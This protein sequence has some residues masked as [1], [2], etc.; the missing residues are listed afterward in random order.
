MRALGFEKI[1]FFPDGR[2]LWVADPVITSC[3]KKFGTTAPEL[4]A[5]VSQKIK[6]HYRVASTKSPS[7]VVYASRSKARGRFI[8]NEAEVLR[9]ISHLAPHVVCFEDLSFAEQ[10]TLMGKTKM[11]ISIHGAGL[12]NM[13]FMPPGGSVIE[14]LPKRNGLFDYNRMRNSFR[15]DACFIRLAQAFG[16][17]HIP[18]ICAHDAP[19]WRMTHMANIRVPTPKLTEIVDAELEVVPHADM[20]SLRANC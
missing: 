3:P 7:L 8:L 9:S 15:H 14:L 2:N 19:L 17:R 12:T 18:L 1:E 13:M 16:H 5:A 10:V 20:Q 11:F 4:L 6:T